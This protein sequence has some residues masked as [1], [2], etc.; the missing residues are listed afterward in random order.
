[1]Q[2]LHHYLL[3]WQHM[4]LEHAGANVHHMLWSFAC[5]FALFEDDVTAAESTQQ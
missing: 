5:S 2:L 3:E 1:M 4:A